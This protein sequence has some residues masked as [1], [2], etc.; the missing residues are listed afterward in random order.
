MVRA[1]G[2][3][4][5]AGGA[6]GAVTDGMRMTCG[7]SGIT[8]SIF[9]EATFAWRD[10]IGAPTSAGL[11]GS[12]AGKPVSRTGSGLAAAGAP[13]CGD[14]LGGSAADA[15]TDLASMP[16]VVAGGRAGTGSSAVVRA[17]AIGAD[18]TGVASPGRGRSRV[19]AAADRRASVPG[20][21]VVTT[22]GG[23]SGCAA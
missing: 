17:G 20:T 15:L 3:A 16:G 22:T 10:C 8:A 21:G 19:A 13:V 6:S 2:A 9:G 1:V 7:T 4:G 14:G 5:G 12:A 11:T 23:A 18:L